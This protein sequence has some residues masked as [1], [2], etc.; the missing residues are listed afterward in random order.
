MAAIKN[1]MP[2]T[3]RFADHEVIVVPNRLSKA[4]RHAGSNER[5]PVSDAEE[6]LVELSAQFGSWMRDECAQLE[7]ARQR[8]HAEGFTDPAREEL[9]RAAHDIRGHGATFGFPMAAEVADSL[10]QVIEHCPDPTQIPTGFLDQCVDAV[11]A[12]IREHD[13]ANA[14]RVAAEL[15]KSLRAIADEFLG[16]SGRACDDPAA[17]APPPQAPSPTPAAPPLVPD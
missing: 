14:D 11:R 4:I 3:K 6:A 5:D 9:F 13:R 1:G 16:K 12:I 7:Q 17:P 15:A 10:C 8:V 2:G